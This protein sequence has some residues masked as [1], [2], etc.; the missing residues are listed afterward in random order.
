MIS[1]Y[2]ISFVLGTRSKNENKHLKSMYAFLPYE[3]EVMKPTPVDHTTTKNFVV[4][5]I[6]SASVVVL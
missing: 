6:I 3:M 5:L 2:G 4:R 1:F